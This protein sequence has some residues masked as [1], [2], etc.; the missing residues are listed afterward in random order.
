[1]TVILAFEKWREEDQ[2][3]KANFGEPGL[4][5]TVSEKTNDKRNPEIPQ[6]NI[7]TK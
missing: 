5:V 7:L 2:A 3:F 4:H 6:S 1:M